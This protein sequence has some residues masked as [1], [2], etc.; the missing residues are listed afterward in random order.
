MATTPTPEQIERAREIS[1][2]ADVGAQ[3]ENDQANILIRLVAQA[4]AEA[5]VPVSQDK[6]AL[7]D[8]LMNLR[9]KYGQP[10]TPI[11]IPHNLHWAIVEGIMEHITAPLLVEE[12]QPVMLECRK[13]IAT[14]P[15][16]V[17]G[18]DLQGGWFYRDELIASID[19]VLRPPK[20][21]K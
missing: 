11:Q 6:D 14:L 2:A 16:D 5:A 13:V 17:L 3:G 21:T 10:G 19:K 20:E 9:I 1:I 8:W 12:W 15:E 4:I 18:R 7:S